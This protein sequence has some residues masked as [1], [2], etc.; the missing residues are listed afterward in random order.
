MQSV[1]HSLCRNIPGGGHIQSIH[2]RPWLR[3]A[4]HSAEIFQVVVTST[5]Y[6]RD[7][8]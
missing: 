8:G 4:V 7:L 3:E 6:M 1:I 2:E 5:V